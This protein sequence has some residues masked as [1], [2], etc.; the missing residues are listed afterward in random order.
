MNTLFPLAK[1]AIKKVVAEGFKT[2]FIEKVLSPNI[3]YKCL[4][5]IEENKEKP[6]DELEAM[7]LNFVSKNAQYEFRSEWPKGAVKLF[8][9]MEEWQ[10]EEGIKAKVCDIAFANL[11]YNRPKAKEGK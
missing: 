10:K 2:H 8:R 3:D 9:E 5:L 6:D 11:D 1:G 7:V 4:V